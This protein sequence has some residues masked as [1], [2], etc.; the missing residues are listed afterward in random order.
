VLAGFERTL[1]AAHPDTL[2]TLGNLAGVLKDQGDLAAAR[3]MYERTLMAQERALGAE[4][5][6][7]QWT[8]GRLAAL[9]EQ[10]RP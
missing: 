3:E 4:H 7:T 5:P 10:D 9:D 1:G 2:A 8:R 6:D